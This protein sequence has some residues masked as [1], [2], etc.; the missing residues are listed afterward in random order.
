[1][2]KKK[3]KK[4]KSEFHVFGW[5]PG[6]K[7]LWFFWKKFR[8]DMRAHFGVYSSKFLESHVKYFSM[9]FCTDAGSLT[10]TNT[11]VLSNF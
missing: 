3:K 8:G 4:I 9:K 1:M 7:N 11:A 5:F 6:L 2:K 10:L